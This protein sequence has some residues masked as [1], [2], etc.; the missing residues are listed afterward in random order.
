MVK[1]RRV[2][3]VPLITETMVVSKY[4]TLNDIKDKLCS[5]QTSYEDECG[6]SV[7]TC[8]PVS[9]SSLGVVVHNNEHKTLKNVAI[10]IETTI[11]E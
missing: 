11:I 7:F 6:N 10:S 9:I 3:K 8:L 5:I 2:I 4:P 1:T